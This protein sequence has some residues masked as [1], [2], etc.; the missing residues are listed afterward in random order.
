MVASSWR[1]EEKLATMG[2]R[3][4]EG[5]ETALYPDGGVIYM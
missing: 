5:H 2:H 3:N 4:F 1:R